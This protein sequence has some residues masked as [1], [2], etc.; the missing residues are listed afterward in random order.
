MN[1]GANFLSLS[2]SPSIIK[3]MNTTRKMPSVRRRR[4][5]KQSRPRTWKLSV[6]TRFRL[7]NFPSTK[8]RFSGQTSSVWIAKRSHR[9]VD[10]SSIR[11]K[12]TTNAR[13]RRSVVVLWNVRPNL[14][15]VCKS[16]NKQQQQPQ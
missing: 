9:R 1:P 4:S 12:A 11:L 15:T 7:R 3:M 6:T 2:R 10:F 16:S 14:I 8:S 13:R 5:V